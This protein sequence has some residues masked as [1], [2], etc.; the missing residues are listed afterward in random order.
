MLYVRSMQSS[1][2]TLTR[3]SAS[4]AFLVF[5]FLFS[6]KC[7]PVAATLCLGTT[8]ASPNAEMKRSFGVVLSSTRRWPMW[9]DPDILGRRRSLFF[10]AF[11]PSVKSFV[12]KM[13]RCRHIH[14]CAG[15]ISCAVDSASGSRHMLADSSAFDHHRT[16][17][18]SGFMGE[19][20]GH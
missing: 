12:S 11:A 8:I 16:H 17:L 5:L 18:W 20:L 10:L 13:F 15:P 19:P 6:T 2:A 7:M 9:P 4:T 3:W 14:F 1:L